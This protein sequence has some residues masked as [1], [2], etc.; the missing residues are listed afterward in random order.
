MGF[1]NSVLKGRQASVRC[2]WMSLDGRQVVSGS[3]DND[4][5][6]GCSISQAPRGSIRG[7]FRDCHG[8]IDER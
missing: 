5:C 2:V 6:F 7:T 8:C 1:T 4:L 3:D